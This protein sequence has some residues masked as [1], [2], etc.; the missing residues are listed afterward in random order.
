M[1][2]APRRGPRTTGPSRSGVGARAGRGSATARGSRRSPPQESTAGASVGGADRPA[3][4]QA[5]VATS[6]PAATR[7]GT[8]PSAAATGGGRR[9]GRIT[10]RGIGAPE[11]VRTRS[12]LV[13]QVA[14]LGLVFC[15]VALALAVPLRHYLSQRAA[16]STAVSHEQELRVQLTALKQQEQALSDPA[17]IASEAKR[18]LQYVKPGDT[19]YVVHAPPLPK[20]KADASVAPSTSGPWYSTLWDTL[21]DPAA[22]PTPALPTGAPAP[23]LPT[24]APTPVHGVSSSGSAPATTALKTKGGN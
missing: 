12:Q 20:P 10:A 3:P 14:V 16:L 15:A 24:G 17:Y 7:P 18:R 19:V 8:A 5:R 21:A 23:A 9:V 13:K 6:R 2:R 1:D 22:T 11:A 4:R